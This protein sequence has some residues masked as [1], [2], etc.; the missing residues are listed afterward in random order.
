VPDA[1]AILKFRRL[2]ERHHLNERL[3]AEVGHVLQRAKIA[4]KS[5]TIVDATI[6]SAPSSTKNEEK[7]RDPEMHQTRKGKQW[8]FGMKLHIGVDSEIGLAHSAVVTSA[9]VHD[10]HALPKL[11]HGFEQRVYGDSAYHSQAEARGPAWLAARTTAPH[12]RR[13]CFGQG[14]RLQYQPLDGIG[15][16]Q[17]RRSLPDRQQPDRECHPA[18]LPGQELCSV[19]NYVRFDILLWCICRQMLLPFAFPFDLTLT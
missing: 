10:K 7:Q 19:R 14:H 17:R 13:Q 8:Y 4:I 2:L 5:S 11:L 3:F 16:L 9:N 12:G 18:D 6:I 15:A 1:T